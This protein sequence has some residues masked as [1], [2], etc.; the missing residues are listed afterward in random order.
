MSNLLKTPK[1][2]KKAFHQKLFASELED[3]YFKKMKSKV[4]NLSLVITPQL[5][6]GF[7]L[8]QVSSD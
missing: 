7:E 2:C 3:T 6:V 5:K 8:N 4:L 1:E